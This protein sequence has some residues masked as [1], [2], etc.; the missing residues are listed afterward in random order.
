MYPDDEQR[1][2]DK[3]K[4]KAELP[5]HKMVISEF[6]DSGMF[7]KMA[8]DTSLRV[9]IDEDLGRILKQYGITENQY[10]D[11]AKTRATLGAEGIGPKFYDFLR[12]KGINRSEMI[13]AIKSDG[14]K[15]A[16]EA[17]NDYKQ[18]SRDLLKLIYGPRSGE[19]EEETREAI[20]RH[21]SAKKRYHNIAGNAVTK[22]W[23]SLP[24]FD[25][26]ISRMIEEHK[27]EFESALTLQDIGRQIVT[28]CTEAKD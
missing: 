14:D 3:E 2:N 23:Y 24:N 22:D 5:L 11:F 7:K 10:L 18:V 15:S 20:I 1:P 16:A 19:S 26:K 9:Q 27:D 13:N 28:Y 25:S 17:I 8:E 12:E 21:D 4:N 6:L